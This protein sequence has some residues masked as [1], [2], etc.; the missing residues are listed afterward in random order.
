MAPEINGLTGKDYYDPF[1]AD[2]YSLGVILY[3]LLFHELPKLKIGL[4]L[5][6]S[7]E[8][9]RNPFQIENEKWFN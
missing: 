2:I 8:I 5:I 1:K 9:N 3:V 6:K 7:E 4:E